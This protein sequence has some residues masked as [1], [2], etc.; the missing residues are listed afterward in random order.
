MSTT[1]VRRNEASEIASAE[2]VDT[3]LEV[4]VTG[5]GSPGSQCSTVDIDGSQ[6]LEG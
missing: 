4:G 2:N 5:G 1:E 3:K 6:Q